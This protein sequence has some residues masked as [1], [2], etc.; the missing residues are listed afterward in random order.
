MTPTDSPPFLT[1]SPVAHPR[2]DAPEPKPGGNINIPL[3]LPL[4][5]RCQRGRDIHTPFGSQSAVSGKGSRRDGSCRATSAGR[6]RRAR[7]FPSS[8]WHAAQQRFNGLRSC[9]RCKIDLPEGGGHLVHDATGGTD[10]Q[11]L[12]L[13]GSQSLGHWGTLGGAL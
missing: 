2:V 8:H 10:D 6:Q 13:G 4:S 1:M 5:G 9:E 3:H 11:V 7:S 12:H